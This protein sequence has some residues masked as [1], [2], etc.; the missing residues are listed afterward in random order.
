MSS[1]RWAEKPKTTFLPLRSAIVFIGVSLR[2]KKA[3]GS[4]QTAIVLTLFAG[5]LVQLQGME[6]AHYKQLASKGQLQKITVP[7]VGR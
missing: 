4:G 6:S 7:A 5:R 1:T 3:V 2:T